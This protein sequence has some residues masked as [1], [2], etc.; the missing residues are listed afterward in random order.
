MIDFTFIALTFVVFALFALLVKGLEKAR[1]GV[2][3]E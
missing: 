3:D 2:D 1:S